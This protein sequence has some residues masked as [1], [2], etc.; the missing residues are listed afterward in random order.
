MAQQTRDNDSYAW[1]AHFNVDRSYTANGLNQYT[2]AGPATFT[3]DANGNLAS[4]GSTTYLY[5]VENRLVSASG[6]KNAV[7]RYDPL[8]RLYET[9]SGSVTTRFLTDGDELVAE[10]NGS[11]TL[12]RRYTHGSSVDDPVVWYEGT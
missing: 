5:D 8:G 3:Y 10:Y 12:L 7:L 2:A 1:T 4:D 9:V 6:A 11:G